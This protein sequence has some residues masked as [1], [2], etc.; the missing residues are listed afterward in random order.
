MSMILLDS[1]T[2]LGA[3]T[4]TQLAPATPQQH[5]EEVIGALFFLN[6]TAV[7]AGGA[8]PRRCPTRSP[9]RPPAGVGAWC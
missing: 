5:F 9:P 8:R 4:V 2:A 7:A 6:V 1:R 3:G